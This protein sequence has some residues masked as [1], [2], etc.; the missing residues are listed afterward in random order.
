MV[1]LFYQNYFDIILQHN[2]TWM[3]LSVKLVCR[4][5]YCK[6]NCNTRHDEDK[7]TETDPM[8]NRKRIRFLRGLC[9]IPVIGQDVLLRRMRLRSRW[10]VV[11]VSLCLVWLVRWVNIS[12]LSWWCTGLVRKR[13]GHD[14][15]E[16]WSFCI[17]S[18][19]L[20]YKA[21]KAM[22]TRNISD[23]SKWK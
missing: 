8:P 12:C 10:A 19:G 14:Y 18:P 21:Y 17:V 11:R 7:N 4:H 1:C 2:N 22:W 3:F 6:E 16:M 5:F 15:V 23:Y 13:I 9:I 20:N